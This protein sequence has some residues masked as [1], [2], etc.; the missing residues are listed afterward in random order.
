MEVVLGFL[1][2]RLGGRL[3]PLPVSMINAKNLLKNSKRYHSQTLIQDSLHENQPCI[4]EL[5]IAH[6][7]AHHLIWRLLQYA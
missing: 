4:P 5:N 2:V 7:T 6:T 1:A 3:L